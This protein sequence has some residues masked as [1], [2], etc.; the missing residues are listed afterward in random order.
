MELLQLL[1]LLLLLFIEFYYSMLINLYSVCDPK[2][3]EDEIKEREKKG[4]FF[5]E[6][7][8][9]LSFFL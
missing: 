7:S 9:D 3:D 4:D 6:F 8:V 5:V 2:R 1:L